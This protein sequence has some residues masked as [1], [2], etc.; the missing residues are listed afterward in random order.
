[1]EQGDLKERF[2]DKY[3]WSYYISMLFLALSWFVF[4]WGKTVRII[5][6]AIFFVVYILY[7]KNHLTKTTPPYTKFINWFG[8]GI[9]GVFTVMYI[10]LS[11]GEVEIAVW[12]L[13]V[14]MVMI[15]VSTLVFNFIGL[16]KS[17]TLWGIILSYMVISMLLIVF[18]GYIFTISS[19]FPDNGLVWTNSSMPVESPWNFVYFSSSAYYGNAVGDIHPLGFS[20]GLMQFESAFSFVFHIIILGF[21]ITSIKKNK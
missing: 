18:F 16:F 21:I 5:A 13:L 17:Q 1:M 6:S 4:D 14:A 12:V 10:A 7:N 2:L 15:L 19:G 8:V 11:V 20:R 9:F 3:S